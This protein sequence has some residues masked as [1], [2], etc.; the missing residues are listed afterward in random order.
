[1]S[2]PYISSPIGILVVLLGTAS[3]FLYLEKRT[4]WKLFEFLP[5]ILFIFAVPIILSNCALIPFSQAAAEASVQTDTTTNLVPFLSNASPVYGQI[6]KLIL[7]LFIIFML[8]D[9]DIVA[10][11]RVMGRGLGILLMGSV[12]VILGAPIAM[13]CVKH[14]LGPDAWQSFG[15]LS[16]SFIGGAGNMGAVQSMLEAPSSTMGLAVFADAIIFAIWIPILIASKKYANGFNRFTKVDPQRIEI[17]EK[18]SSDFI[19][20]KGPLKMQHILYLLFLG[21]GITWLAS[22]LAGIMPADGEIL[23]EKAWRILLITTFGIALS[24]TRARTIP[25]SHEMAIAMVYLYVASMGAQADLHKVTTEAPWFLLGGFILIFFHGLC[26]VIGAKILRVDLASTAI[27]STA[28]IGGAA[29]APIVAAYHNEK[30]IPMGILMALI[31]YAM[32]NYGGWAA[33]QLCRLVL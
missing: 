16:A 11:V 22:T 6:D 13:L 12:G 33:A 2:T 19:I 24:T 32:S 23:T 14:G 4:Q 10:A 9:V 17:L 26:C 31:G 28:N 27:A 21:W 8:L 29:T 25:G 5:P 3:L 18:K 15:I 1:M 20:D 30:L 7:P